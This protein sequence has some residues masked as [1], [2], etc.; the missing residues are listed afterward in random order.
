M[1]NV[2]VLIMSAGQSRRFGDP[3]QKKTFAQL[4]NRPVWSHSLELF[5]RCEEVGQIIMVIDPADRGLLTSSDFFPNDVLLTEGGKERFHSVENGLRQVRPDME[6][7]AVHDAAR[8]CITLNQVKSVFQAALQ[9]GAAILATPITGTIKRV[10]SVE[11]ET[12]KGTQEQGLEIVETVSRENLWEAQTPQVFNRDLLMRAYAERGKVHAT[13]D[14]H[15]V[16]QLGYPVVIVP[17]EK[18][19]IK[20]TTR[21]DLDFAEQVLR[22]RSLLSG[23]V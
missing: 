5:R 22:N 2:A 13:D 4:R 10:Q 23:T 20:I 9:Q 19:N 1:K 12:E 7:V 3:T 21:A 17:G 11:R 8:P 18:T 6:F 14:A 15:L 16:Q